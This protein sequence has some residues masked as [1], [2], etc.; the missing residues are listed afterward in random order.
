MKNNSIDNKIIKLMRIKF[1]FVAMIALLILQSFIICISI[2][3]T[4][5][6]M[7][8]R[9]DIL[10]DN[11]YN[12]IVNENENESVEAIYFYVIVDS[13]GATTKINTTNNRSVKP[14]QA[15]KYYRDVIKNNKTEAFYNGY[16]YKIYELDTGQVGIFILRTAMIED[17]KKTAETLI[18]SSCFGLT[19]TF[20][21]LIFLSKKIVQPIA[22]SYQ[23]Q[24]EFITSASHELKTPL[25]VIMADIDILKMDYEDNEWIEDIKEQ[26]QQLT[27]MT[28]SLVSLARMDER[29]TNIIKID[30]PISDIAQDIA[31]SYKSLSIINNKNFSYNIE[32]NIKYCGDENQIRQLFTI[33]LDNAF[34]YSSNNGNIIFTMS[35]NKNAVKFQVKNDVDYIDKNEVNK[36]FDRFYRADMTSSKIKGY[37]LGLSIAKE[38]VNNHNGKIKILACGENQI[39]IDVVF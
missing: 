33:L 20:I 35:T 28:H 2:H 31:H 22:L 15:T 3:N 11:I 5:K 38:I 32:H 13:N 26:A 34:K 39:I 1:I 18:I 7:L 25:T 12:S 30:F 36:M 9:T 14:K 29:G 27:E 6:K 16:R 37:G 17:I 21:I 4:Y 23:K 10:F 8:N 19:I 24:K